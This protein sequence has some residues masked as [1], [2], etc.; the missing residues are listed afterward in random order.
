MTR[1]RDTDRKLRAWLIEGADRA[2]ERFVWAAMD[3]IDR[4]PQRAAWRTTLERLVGGGRL[5]RLSPVVAVASTVAVVAVVLALTV[6]RPNSDVGPA[7]QFEAADLVAI[8]VWED[9]R[10]ATW[11]LDNLVS[12]PTEVRRIPIRSLPAA[13]IRELQDPPGLLAGRYTDFSG[14]DAAF[15]SW[16]LLFES[17]AQAADALGFY[18]LELEGAQAWGLGPPVN[19]NLGDESYRYEGETTAFVGPPTG[20]DPIPADVYLW[21]DGNVLL[22]LGGW[23]DVDPAE[24]RAVAEAMDRR[25]DAAL[26]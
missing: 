20:V 16:A 23:F 22:A 21:R 2:P 7:R 13:Q 19:A 1:E 6:L 3:E 10:P 14:P 4:L 17:E 26:R 15:M 25:A 24:L 8:V 5:S 18:R 12:N 9:T 11:R